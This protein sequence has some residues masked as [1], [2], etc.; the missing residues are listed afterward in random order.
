MTLPTPSLSQHTS[1]TYVGIYGERSQD[2]SADFNLRV[3]GIVR[4]SQSDEMKAPKRLVNRRAVCCPQV[5]LNLGIGALL[6][7]PLLQSQGPP[8]TFAS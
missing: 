1:R 2:G 6:M 5:A 8:R 3:L 7:L 4:G